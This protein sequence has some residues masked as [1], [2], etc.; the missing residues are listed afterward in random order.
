MPISLYIFRLFNLNTVFYL[1]KYFFKT[2]V[3][4][5]KSK[6]EIYLPV[7]KKILVYDKLWSSLILKFYKEDDIHILHCRGEKINLYI[8]FVCMM[9]GLF[10]ASDY[11]EQY[12]K[13]IKPKIIITFIDN[14]PMFWKLRRLTNIKTT[15]IQFGVKS[16]FRD[17]FGNKNLISKKHNYKVDLMFVFNPSIGKKYNS[18]I[19][20]KYISIGSFRNNM[21]QITKNK[22]RKEICF[23][24]TFRNIEST[25][26]ISHDITQGYYDK[27]LS[28]FLNWLKK[29]CLKNNLKINIIGKNFGEN[30][31][32]EEKYYERFFFQNKYKYF[33]STNQYKKGTS[34]YNLTDKYKYVFTIDSTL[35][36]ENLSRNGRTGFIGNM[37]NKY[38][39]NTIK[40]GWNEKLKLNGP[41]WTSKN[42]YREFERVFDFVINGK[43]SSWNKARKKLIN[44][45]MAYDYG[46]KVFKK[47]IEKI[48]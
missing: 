48:L 36:I 15:F 24:S 1:V 44:N 43:E 34:I 38:P 39:L 3:K 2:I 13:K 8:V 29:Y 32:Q 30:G 5:L 27:N 7:N 9:K 25:K 10:K 6:W 21:I 37:P 12:I 35:G 42:T 11:Y 20:G 28:F 22:K 33:R 4:I 41:F 14:A 23:I 26:I 16:H 40:F 31:V 45:V 19:K 47:E 17:V 46:N 18:F